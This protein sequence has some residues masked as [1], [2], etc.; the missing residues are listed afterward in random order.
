MRNRLYRILQK[1][2][3]RFG[4]YTQYYPSDKAI[5]YHLKSKSIIIQNYELNKVCSSLRSAKDHLA[6][7]SLLKKFVPLW[8]A[9]IKETTFVLGAGGGESSLNFFRKVKINDTYYFEK[10]YYSLHD[11]LKRIK[12]FSQNAYNIIDRFGVVAP[13]LHRM[14][15]GEAFVIVY[16]EFLNLEKLD[17]LEIEVSF[18]NLSKKLYKAS[19]DEAFIGL[20]NNVPDYIKDF[21]NHF[22]YKN[23]IAQA[24]Q[25]LLSHR[26]SIKR[27]EDEIF[28][29]KIILTHGDIQ[30]KN[31]F[32]DCI[33]IDWD[34][35]GL[36]PIGFDLAF[37]CFH[38]LLTKRVKSIS[39]DWLNKNFKMDINTED[40]DDLKRNYN[41]FLF[42]FLATYF[43]KDDYKE[44]ELSLL[45]NLRP[46]GS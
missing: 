15:E 26:I 24:E 34:T 36:Y 23:K 29:S 33:L 32:K 40:W 6:Y 38:L 4:I 13:R 37:S 27:M 42:V 17:N 25:R 14:Y 39:P 18:I 43:K 5:H 21:R 44:I 41:Y 31:G 28:H 1:N 45:E 10:V 19:L 22:E 16:F 3:Y 11:D 8:N 30:D 9:E 7:N 2:L 12:W 35:F 46:Y 20:K